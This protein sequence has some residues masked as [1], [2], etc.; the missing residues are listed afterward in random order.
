MTTRNKN[1]LVV[2]ASVAVCVVLA[3]AGFAAA[4]D[5]NSFFSAVPPETRVF[6][7]D[8]N[9]ERLIN[10]VGS[11]DIIDVGDSLYGVMVIEQL[12]LL[13]GGVPSEVRLRHSYGNSEFSA[14]FQIRVKTK[15]LNPD[16]TTYTFGF[17][18]DP[19]FDTSG[20][21]TMIRMYED[22]EPPNSLSD[23]DIHDFTHSAG[24]TLGIDMADGA[25]SVTDG[26]FYWAL[27]L[28]SP[29][30]N[31]IGIGGDDITAVG[32]P[33]D[34]LGDAIFALDRTTDTGAAA[35]SIH[36]LSTLTNALGMTGEFI[37]TSEIGGPVAGSPWPL[38]SHTNV[39]F[40]STAPTDEP[41]LDIKPYSV[42]N[43]LNPKRKGN[44][45]V[46]L[47]GS[48]TFDVTEVDVFTILLEG[49]DPLSKGNKDPG[50]LGPANDDEFM[51]LWF[52][53]DNQEILAAIGGCAT[54]LTLTG[55]LLD[56]TPFSATDSIRI[57]G[58]TNGL[59]AGFGKLGAMVAP[60][61]A[62]LSLLMLGG[63]LL[64]RRKK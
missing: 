40:V 52:H 10:R 8:E 51:D 48:E 34:R 41:N 15:T 58:C 47:L 9:A 62:T 11:P 28:V 64:L 29:G 43:T 33:S 53:F 54:E 4:G 59:T 38:A 26:A 37:G 50:N 17:E 39:E 20:A 63:G 25:G 13:R 5:L 6:G 35:G 19:V 18:P 22:Y 44:M 61:P 49:V 36:T 55:N 2:H 31:W 42:P 14:E 56:G 24:E 7:S 45:A 60:E 1:M 23:F 30:N 32:R 16:G 12:N 46:A 3:I 27:G 57:L 21:G